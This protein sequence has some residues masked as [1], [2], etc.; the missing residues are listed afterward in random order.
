MIF[1]SQNTITQ[2][3]G[4]CCIKL[5]N[6]FLQNDFE[7]FCPALNVKCMY[8]VHRVVHYKIPFS[9]TIYILL[10]SIHSGSSVHGTCPTSAVL[11]ILVRIMIE[12]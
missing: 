11:T 3:N 9:I 6:I 8:N 2:L 4:L 5:L 1:V 12:G 10:L 7:L